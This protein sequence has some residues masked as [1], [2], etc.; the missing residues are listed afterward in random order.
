VPLNQRQVLA[1]GLGKWPTLLWLSLATL[2]AMATWF[3]ASAVVPALTT[4]WNLDEAGRA[5]LTM[6]VQLG[7]VVG[8]LGSALLNL[9]DR[10]SARYLFS[11]SAFLAAA[12]TAL[13]PTASNLTVALLLR[14]LTGFAL[15]G[16]YPVAM[17]LVATWTRADRGFGIG[18]LVGAITLGNAMPH[19]LNAA[20][21]AG[22]WQRVLYG[23]AGLAAIGGVIA[24]SVAHEG[25]YATHIPPFDWRQVGRI[26]RQRELV[27]VNLGYLGHMW[28]LFAMLT[29][30]PI[31]LAVSFQASGHD[32]M[33]ASATAF[34]AISMGAFSSLAAGIL[35]DRMGRTTITIAALAVS[36][37]CALLVGWL[38]GAHPTVLVPLCLL[39]GL[40]VS[41]DSAQF[42]AAASELSR[43]EYIGTALTLQTCLGFLLT[44]ATI[45]L[46]PSLEHWVGWGWA[47]AALALGPAVGI[48][49]MARLRRVLAVTPSS[50]RAQAFIRARGGHS[51]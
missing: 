37:S 30:L 12:A 1:P 45:R 6:S 23:A 3:S 28:E 29:W 44:L 26:L 33:W 43:P 20:G 17:R 39:W 31:F 7:F 34:I 21:G 49:A 15:V 32:P 19:L 8:A 18:L 10:I 46:V 51:R 11:L 2:L 50:E 24:A 38:F 27:L 42:S 47:F 14:L 25:P 36:G 5:W 40:A 48:W 9:A 22:D 4:A 35:A 13:V 41:P 16:V